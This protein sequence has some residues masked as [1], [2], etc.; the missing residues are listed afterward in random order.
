MTGYLLDVDEWIN[1]ILAQ[2]MLGGGYLAL[3]QSLKRRNDR[4]WT[5]RD[6]FQS[7]PLAGDSCLI[8]GRASR[9]LRTS[10]RGEL[11]RALYL[12]RLGLV[13]AD[14]SWRSFELDTAS[15][16]SVGLP[17]CLKVKATSSRPNHASDRRYDLYHH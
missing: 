17:C 11:R 13:P 2:L 1:A 10:G 4:H 14:S 7:C 12:V 5:C 8:P 9:P 6:N 16:H 3:P 15:Y